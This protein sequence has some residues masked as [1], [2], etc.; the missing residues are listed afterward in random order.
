ME[1]KNTTKW[2]NIN[3]F[4]NYDDVKIKTS[5]AILFQINDKDSKFYS[6]TFW[7]PK[8]C[9]EFDY[10]SGLWQNDKFGR[11]VAD[12]INEYGKGATISFSEDFKIKLTKTDADDYK[13]VLD[14]IEFSGKEFAKF[15][16]VENVE[17]TAYEDVNSKLRQ[18]Y[19]LGRITN[20]KGI[21]SRVLPK[22]EEIKTAISQ[23]NEVFENYKKVETS[24]VLIKDVTR[25]FKKINKMF[26]KMLACQAA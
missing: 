21:T 6:Y 14:S 19:N 4:V 3:D 18:L 1:L 23:L 25:F 2:Y 26:E 5:K 7:L 24:E 22:A 8:K 20:E 16:G 9:V 12:L 13:K 17:V 11:P 10:E 15:C